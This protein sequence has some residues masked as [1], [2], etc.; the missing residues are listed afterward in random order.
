MLKGDIL[1]EV[2]KAI[3]LRKVRVAKGLK[4]VMMPDLV[5][6]LKVGC[7]TDAG[8]W[9]QSWWGSRRRYGLGDPGVTPEKP[10]V[11]L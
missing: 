9:S 3:E 5:G 7:C 1:P 11:T 8:A 6:F 2:G 4:M 10:S